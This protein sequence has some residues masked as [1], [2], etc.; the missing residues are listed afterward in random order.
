MKH[1]WNK[2][3]FQHNALFYHCKAQRD[4]WSQNLSVILQSFNRLVFGCFYVFCLC[5]T[6]DN[7]QKYLGVFFF[8]KITIA[9]VWYEWMLHMY[10]ALIHT[11]SVRFLT[12]PERYKCLC[13]QITK[14]KEIQHNDL[15]IWFTHTH[16]HTYNLSNSLSLSLRL[17]CCWHRVRCHQPFTSGARSVQSLHAALPSSPSR[18]DFLSTQFLSTAWQQH[19]ICLL[20]L[21]QLIAW[22][23]IYSLPTPFIT[24]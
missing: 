19:T 10:Q 23:R 14:N 3:W 20:T 8:S 17:Q 13:Y 9:F 2:P 21:P 7:Y 1:P 12:K 16:T 18:W 11:A 6:F 15:V 22:L 24:I 4:D 5:H